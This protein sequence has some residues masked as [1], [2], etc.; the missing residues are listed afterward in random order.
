MTRLIQHDAKGPA[1]IKVGDKTIGVCQCGLSKTK[2]FCDG[3]HKTTQDEKD[4]FVYIYD[5]QG[6]RVQLEDMFPTQRQVFEK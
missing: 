1:V 4:G 5:T 3:S 2:P 6:K